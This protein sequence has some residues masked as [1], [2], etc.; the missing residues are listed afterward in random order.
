MFQMK[1][2]V[3]ERTRR[4][5]QPVTSG[6]K[7]FGDGG[8]AKYVFVHGLGSTAHF[9]ETSAT[10]AA[11]VGNCVIF[12]LPGHGKD[13]RKRILIDSF[14]HYVQMVAEIVDQLDT[15][16]KQDLILVGHSLGGLIALDLT[17]NFG[18]GG[19]LCLIDGIC[20]SIVES[21]QQPFVRSVRNEGLPLSLIARW[22]TSAAAVPFP[23]RLITIFAKS[24]A[25]RV[26]TLW[27]YLAHPARDEAGLVADSLQF[28][29]TRTAGRG[30]REVSTV[31]SRRLLEVDVPI[32]IINGAKDRLLRDADRDRIR[33]TLNTIAW[34]EISEAGHWPML[35]APQQFLPALSET[36][37]AIRPRTK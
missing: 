28:C 23:N 36:L 33:S 7:Y 31:E 32:G 30:L 15:V 11:T 4:T 17:R 5:E 16:P 26:S 19:G 1:E 2:A 27:P 29:G 35:D 21:L 13:R 3:V 9:L 10:Q 22:I 24:R 20:F 18:F 34:T 6:L 25:G 8:P 37:L 12:D 14:D